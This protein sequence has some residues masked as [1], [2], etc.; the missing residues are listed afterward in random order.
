MSAAAGI[1]PTP[2]QISVEF[3]RCVCLELQWV[4]DVMMS[5]NALPV[6]GIERLD[7]KYQR[8]TAAVKRGQRRNISRFFWERNS[9]RRALSTTSDMVRFC[10]AASRLS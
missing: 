2:F 10:R 7:P 5:T 8:E 9:P 1:A 3:A 4:N 6:V